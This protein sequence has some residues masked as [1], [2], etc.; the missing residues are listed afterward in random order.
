MLQV[1]A[2]YCVGDMLKMNKDVFLALIWENFG[3]LTNLI[4]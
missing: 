2:L 1:P 3:R 4:K